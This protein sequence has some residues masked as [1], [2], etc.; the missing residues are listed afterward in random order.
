ML[1]KKEKT[2]EKTRERTGVNEDG[3]GNETSGQADERT[4]WGCAGCERTR[5]SVMW[6][7]RARENEGMG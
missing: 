1:R 3:G 5:R 7:V 6:N 2:R 4:E